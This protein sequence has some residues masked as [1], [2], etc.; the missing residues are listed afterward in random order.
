MLFQRIYNWIKYKTLPSSFLF[1]NRLFIERDSKHRRVL[2]NFG[3]SFRNSKWSNYESYNIKSHFKTNYFKYIFW[4]ISF[5]LFIYFSFNFNQYYVWSYFFNNIS[6][7]FWISID[8][9]DYYLSFL[10]WLFSVLFSLF[11]NLIY[12]YLFFNSFSNNVFKKENLLNKFST[13]FYLNFNKNSVYVSKHDLNW[14]L[15]SWLVNSNSTKNTKILEKLFVSDVSKKWWNNNYDF[16]IKLYKVSYFLNF[17]SDKTY[18]FNLSSSLNKLMDKNFK[19]NYTSVVT[20]FNNNNLINT[21]SNLILFYF[22]KQ[23]KNYFQIK[24]NDSS[25][26][27]FLKNNY[28]WNLY[29]FNNELSKYNFL[30]KN[31]DG[32]FFLN[33]FNYQKF[34]FLISNYEELWT[35]NL[36]LKNQINFSKW[37]RWLYRYS[38]LHRKILKNSHKLTLA[39]K[40]INGGFYDSQI[41]NQNIWSTNQLNK[42]NSTKIFSS[43]FN[44]FYENLISSKDN[45]N[46]NFK[47]N[48]N[49]NN[50]QTFSLELLHFY[51]NSY[52]WYLKRFYNF[53]TLSTNSIKSKKIS[54]NSKFEKINEIFNENNNFIQKKNIF[55]T[56]LLNS[57]FNNLNLY[58]HFNNLSHTSLTLNQLFLNLNK[59]N[60]NFKDI[61][62]LINTNDFFTENDLDILSSITMPLNKNNKLSY[63][64]YIIYN[65]KTIDMK[66]TLNCSIGDD[67]INFYDKERINK[68]LLFSLINLDKILLNDVVYLSLFY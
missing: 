41:F 18:V 10:L 6:F 28:E 45:N 56:Y 35:L 66:N 62:L 59:T 26:L 31:K 39:K 44:I 30:I 15:Y 68:W 17:L 64:S 16:F 61:Y 43:I 25:S 2:S 11:F 13:Q 23:Y 36:F 33:D 57:S 50:N 51:E 54:N 53:N 9:F 49:N 24:N 3:L 42:L 38:I 52:F 22:L 29:N 5:I 46:L 67:G 40:L 4:F 60:D 65:H 7:I 20:Y 1:K 63:Y 55:L 8:S 58:S 19:N 32:L 21:N 48:T 47:I 12:S 34:S 27:K 14:I 37:N